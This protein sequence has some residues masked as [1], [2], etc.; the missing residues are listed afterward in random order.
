MTFDLCTSWCRC[1]SKVVDTA[2]WCALLRSKH[3]NSAQSLTFGR[4]W[5]QEWTPQF[6]GRQTISNRSQQLLQTIWLELS[7]MCKGAGHAMACCSLVLVLRKT[8]IFRTYRPDKKTKGTGTGMDSGSPTA[9]SLV[10]WC[11]SISEVSF[12][13][14]WQDQSCSVQ[15]A[16][17]PPAVFWW[18]DFVDPLRSPAQRTIGRFGRWTR[19]TLTR[20][21][22]EVGWTWNTEAALKPWRT[23]VSPL[24]DACSFR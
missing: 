3:K 19:Y 11:F 10:S 9:A 13:R 8:S 4:C 15:Q 14:C 22:W 23:K 20:W 18:R 17:R 21:P 1:F 12:C 16:W 6:D 24:Q 5:N 7:R 2:S